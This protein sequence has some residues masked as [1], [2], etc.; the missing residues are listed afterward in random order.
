MK[1]AAH[2][3]LRATRAVL[4]DGVKKCTEGNLRKHARTEIGQRELQERQEMFRKELSNKSCQSNGRFS[5]DQGGFRQQLRELWEARAQE[6]AREE[7]ELK[8]THRK[9]WQQWDCSQGLPCVEAKISGYYFQQLREWKRRR[10]R[11][12]RRIWRIRSKTGPHIPASRSISP[13]LLSNNRNF[14]TEFPVIK[15]INTLHL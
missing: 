8:E 7:R 4:E 5:K 1:I 3:T 15:Y 13:Y 2:R 14:L 9:T 10:S 11:R 6:R 12:R